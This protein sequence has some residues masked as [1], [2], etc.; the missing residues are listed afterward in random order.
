MFGFSKDCTIKKEMIL[1][2]DNQEESVPS[3]VLTQNIGSVTNQTIRKYLQE[4]K[5]N[6]D[7]LYTP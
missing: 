7:N 6:I 4:I 5:S 1:D 2:L 3:Q